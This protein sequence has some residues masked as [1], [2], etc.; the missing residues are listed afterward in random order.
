M[1]TKQKSILI[2]LFSTFLF[3][4]AVTYRICNGESLHDDKDE[5]RALRDS[6]VD[7]FQEGMLHKDTALVMQ[8]WSISEHLLAV[9][10]DHA[11]QCYYHR[12]ILLGWLGRMKEARENK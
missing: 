5:Y 9:D 11:A 12:A 3:T 7:L 6:M 1:N 2:V 8:S 10:N 4:G